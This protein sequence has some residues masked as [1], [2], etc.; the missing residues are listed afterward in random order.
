M[1]Y[2]VKI[3]DR[4]FEVRIDDTRG[5]PILAIVDGEEFE[6]WPQEES[7]PVSA[8]AKTTA[9]RS[10]AHLPTKTAGSTSVRAPIPG[11]IVAIAVKVGDEVAHGQEL[12]TLE[13]MKMKNSIRAPQD[14]KIAAVHIIVGQTVKHHDVL[15]EF[16]N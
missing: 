8:A 7:R 4:V 6:V 11:V 1:I 14:G 16:E 3:N 15:I 2:Q 5:R 13:A 10:A 12:C 9:Q